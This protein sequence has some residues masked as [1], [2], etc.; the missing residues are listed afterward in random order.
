MTKIGFANTVL[1]L[2][3]KQK[4]LGLPDVFN[5]IVLVLSGLYPVPGFENNPFDRGGASGILSNTI[6]SWEMNFDD[7]LVMGNQGADSQFRF[8]LTDPPLAFCEYGFGFHGHRGMLF[9]V[10]FENKYSHMPWFMQ[11]CQAFIPT[12][13]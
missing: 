12:W 8:C 11:E 10:K 7:S 2:A 5:T 3:V 6:A 9:W 4:S 1:A 13:G